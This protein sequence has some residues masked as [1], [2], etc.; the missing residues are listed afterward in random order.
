[1]LLV[2]VPE[3]SVEGCVH[4]HRRGTHDVRLERVTDVDDL[5]WLY[6]QSGERRF[7]DLSP[8]FEK[9]NLAGYRERI[10]VPCDPER[11]EHAGIR[12]DRPSC[13]RDEPYLETRETSLQRFERGSRLRVEVRILRGIARVREYA[14]SPFIDEVRF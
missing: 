12:A 11:T 10:E 7:E 3:P 9:A 2:S 13:V 6:G 4:P 1:M 8:W 14:P 5:T